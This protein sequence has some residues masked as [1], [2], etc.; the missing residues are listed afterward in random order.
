MILHEYL[1]EKVQDADRKIA[2]FRK[3]QKKQDIARRREKEVKP[4]QTIGS[5]PDTCPS[6]GFDSSNPLDLDVWF[7]TDDGAYCNGCGNQPA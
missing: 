3:D 6:C 1:R 5:L 2:L 7:Q 4:I